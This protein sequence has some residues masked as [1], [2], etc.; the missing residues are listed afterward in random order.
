MK[1]IISILLLCMLSAAQ[2]ATVSIVAVPT[3]WRLENYAGNSVVSAWFTGSSCTNGVLT[4]PSQA[5]A[6]D[7]NRFWA[8]VLAAKLTQKAIFVFYDDAIGGCQMISYGMDG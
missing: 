8:L 1:K 2:A 6:A 3:S 7:K 5:T 4:F